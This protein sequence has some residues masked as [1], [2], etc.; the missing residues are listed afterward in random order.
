MNSPTFFYADSSDFEFE[1]A[2][3]SIMDS[4]DSFAFNP[5]SL[6]SEK[7]ISNI[8][9]II[10]KINDYI[11]NENGNYLNNKNNNL[12]K[13]KLMSLLKNR[14]NLVYHKLLAND[15]EDDDFKEK[16]QSLS[17]IPTIVEFTYNDEKN[18]EKEI[19]ALISIKNVIG[20]DILLLI[21]KDHRLI[22]EIDSSS[23]SEGSFNYVET[24]NNLANKVL[25]NFRV[26]IVDKDTI[27]DIMNTLYKAI[28]SRN[29][30]SSIS[31]VTLALNMLYR[32]LYV[33]VSYDN[34]DINKFL[35]LKHFEQSEIND[36][37]SLN[38]K[39]FN[40][41][42]QS[43]EYLNDVFE[44]INNSKG[45]NEENNDENIDNNNNENNK[46]SYAHDNINLITNTLEKK[47][48]NSV[49]NSDEEDLE[50]VN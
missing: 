2:I 17:N 33:M 45:K 50:F 22:S 3:D 7:T 30:L 9:A 49:E 21:T 35:N 37:Y 23:I 14:Y 10:S 4:L 29:A 47:L 5:N 46:V 19:N 15:L 43:N 38:L 44:F 39:L 28:I 8:E 6:S 34:K 25:T 40:P 13:T 11:I 42:S 12:Y 31:K 26:A 16:I 27:T 20:E 48:N 1:E 32:N 18:V 36:N 24:L 41:S